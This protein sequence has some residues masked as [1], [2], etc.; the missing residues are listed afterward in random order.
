LA[1]PEGLV[2]FDKKR[3]VLTTSPLMALT[4]F[5]VNDQK[6]EYY[7]GIKLQSDQN[8]IEIFFQY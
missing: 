3:D 1:T 4:G 8:S 6:R 7:S 2:S 5:T